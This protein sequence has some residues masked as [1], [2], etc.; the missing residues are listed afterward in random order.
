VGPSGKIHNTSADELAGYALCQDDDC[1]KD[2]ASDSHEPAATSQVIEQRLGSGQP[3]WR[4]FFGQF[5]A[6]ACEKLQSHGR[7]FSGGFPPAPA[8]PFGV[9]SVITVR[10]V[11]EAARRSDLVEDRIQKPNSSV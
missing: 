3:V 5:Q 8:L 4:L 10:N 9:G 7:A 11:V 2:K 1:C 6:Q